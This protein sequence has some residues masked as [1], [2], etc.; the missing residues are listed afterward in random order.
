[1]KSLTQF[2]IEYDSFSDWLRLDLFVCHYRNR[3]KSL[4]VYLHKSSADS[5]RRVLNA[6]SRLKALRS[7]DICLET[8]D[9]QMEKTFKVLAGE[10]KQ[11]SKLAIGFRCEP[12]LQPLIYGSIKW[13]RSVARLEL[14]YGC[15]L[16]SPP[17]Y[18]R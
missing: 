10:C 4:S 8:V 18:G 17:Y 2:F 15:Y 3:L 7:L 1:A 6:I 13:F 16:H 14:T 12:S 9:A 5:T 11:L